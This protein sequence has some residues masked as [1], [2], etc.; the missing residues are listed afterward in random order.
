MNIALW[1]LQVLL[2]G[3]FGMTGFMKGI[4]T[5]KARE[6]MPWA[7]DSS[8]TKVRFVG[9]LEILAA[10]GMLLPMIFNIF[11]WLTPL[12]AAGLTLIQILAIFTVHI[13]R[14]EF[15]SL[16]MNIVLLV[17]SFLVAIGRWSLF[18]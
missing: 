6:Q 18:A 9:I 1:I 12:A 4:T 3:M 16:L 15:T 7:K 14:K 10:L 11:P 17:L 8:V 5:N 2:A 13:P